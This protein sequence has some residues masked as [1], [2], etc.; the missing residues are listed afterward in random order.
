[1]N[2]HKS[3][4]KNLDLLIKQ[5]N[6]LC[7]SVPDNFDPDILKK[8]TE[9]A[10][11]KFSKLYFLVDGME[12]P[13]NVLLAGGTGVG[14]STIF[15][16]LLGEDISKVSRKRATTFNPLIGYNTAKKSVFSS[17]NFL[18]H[19]S[20]VHENVEQNKEST[21]TMIHIQKE[22]IDKNIA[23][24]DAPDFDSVFKENAYTAAAL[25]DLADVVLFVFD[26][27]KYKDDILWER[28]IKK[29]S[30]HNSNII[31][32]LNK[33]PNGKEKTKIIKD[34]KKTKISFGFSK[35]KEVF[36]DEV[37]PN[38]RFP[39][40][41][42]A[43]AKEILTEALKDMVSA[44]NVLLTKLQSSSALH[45]FLSHETSQVIQRLR[46]ERSDR[47][48]I[49]N[50][51]DSCY[52]E[53]LKKAL[54]KIEENRHIDDKEIVKI[55][56]THISSI[57][58]MVQKQL[59]V[60]AKK[61]YKKAMEFLSDGEKTFRQEKDTARSLLADKQAEN[62]EL[63]FQLFFE[64]EKELEPLFRAKNLS[65]PQNR[66]D[67]FN[68]L[69]SFFKKEAEQVQEEL[70][71]KIC[72]KKESLSWKGKVVLN[73]LD[74]VVLVFMLWASYFYIG[75]IGVSAGEYIGSGISAIFGDRI[76]SLILGQR[77]QGEIL[78]WL[79][80]RHREIY[81]KI[82]SLEKE[83]IIKLLMPAGKGSDIDE[84]VNSIE[85]LLLSITADFE[86]ISNKTLKT[87]KSA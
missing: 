80:A 74:G 38:Q 79:E 75:G 22:S 37:F 49:I 54:K 39:S 84:A 81:Q 17:S 55:I 27:N 83:R 11:E 85:S 7:V 86:D 51:V 82:F 29:I 77:E 61:I 47:K 31:F 72:E 73:S 68:T 34:F 35:Y 25:F 40:Q 87:Q 14:K 19:F 69:R 76:F 1:M 56:R 65:L 3:L 13:A 26:I 30:Q 10:K 2:T 46:D 33:L 43:E 44:P 4:L 67:F 66:D 70:K 50:K 71:E 15:N 58:S 12:R 60:G 36:L 6:L 18:P 21:P 5:L 59:A 9:L 24:I 42:P 52:Q 16:T 28:G 41:L 62:L 20:H 45:Q 32:V 53:S 64:L 63:L 8:L 57:A 48:E 23:L 78:S